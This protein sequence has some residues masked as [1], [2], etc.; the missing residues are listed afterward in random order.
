MLRPGWPPRR[1]F[2]PS[3]YQPLADALAA[4]KSDHA[5]F[6]FTE[7]E[8]LLGGPLPPLARRTR[9]W[10]TNQ[11]SIGPHVRAWLDAGWQVAAVELAPQMVT[12]KRQHRPRGGS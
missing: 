7:I 4:Q 5:R 2:H 11:R 6:T 1:Q 8:A 12:F 3:K 10:W 9:R